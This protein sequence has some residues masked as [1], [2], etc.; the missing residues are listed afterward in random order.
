[1]IELEPEERKRPSDAGSGSESA[2]TGSESALFL[3][4][5][6]VSMYKQRL[7]RNGPV[8]RYEPKVVKVQ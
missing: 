5:D 2:S 8:V 1:M 4:H 6:H 3:G 7:D